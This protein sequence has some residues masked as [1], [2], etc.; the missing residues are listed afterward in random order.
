MHFPASITRPVEARIRNEVSRTRHALVREVFRLLK[1]SHDA[2]VRAGD[3]NA[4][5]LKFGIEPNRRSLE[6]IIDLT[7][8]RKL[9]TRHFSVGELFYD[10]T[11]H[12]TTRTLS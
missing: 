5:M 9:T 12:D 8:D 4:A 7:F 1:E 2:A 11:R 6:T 10:T 3:K